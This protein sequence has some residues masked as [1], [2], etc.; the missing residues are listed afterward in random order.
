MPRIFILLCLLLAL[1]PAALARSG[2]VQTIDGR[3]LKG[4][5]QFTNGVFVV[6]GTNNIPLPELLSLSFRA[7][8]P[9]ATAARG[10]GN[11]LLGYYF[12]NTALSGDVFVRL[13]ESIDFDWETAEPG[14]EI[15]T[16]HFSVHWSGDLEVPATGDYQ[17]FLKADDG[18][19]FSLGDRMV[20]DGWQT[21]GG[22]E[23]D[24]AAIGL[25][26]GVRYP[27]QFQYFNSAGKAAVRLM[28]SGPNMP[29]S[30]IPRDRLFAKSNLPGHTATLADE[31]TG[32]LGTYYTKTDFTGGTWS[33]IDPTVD[34]EWSSL[35][36]VPGVSR[37]N[38]SVRWSGQILA[39]YTELYSFYLLADEPFRLWLD[40][41]IL[42]ATGGDTFF[43]E[44]R[45]SIALT[46]GERH[47]IRLETQSTGGN[48]IAKVA[49]SSASTPKAPVP[50]TH[51]F[52]SKPNTLHH[53]VVD[54]ADKSP[55]GI[56]MRN[57][58]FLAGSI[59]RATESSLRMTGRSTP[60]STVN[61]AR[62]LLQP[63]PRKLED[64]IPPGRSG[65]L[66]AKGDFV[67][68]EF[69][70]IENG[71]VRTSSI[72]FGLRTYDAT[73]DVIAIALRSPSASAFT[74]EVQ[75]ADGTRVFATSLNV[76]GDSLVI[77]DAMTGP[78]NI[79][80]ADVIEI[81]RAR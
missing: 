59:E 15:P 64:R 61:I 9:V 42:I 47:D 58:S 30:L 65:L 62:I 53:V 32:L 70:G 33:R 69:N 68:A 41:R 24:S 10:K 39:D 40:G 74:F 27:I 43:F 2:R 78:L 56:L 8:V 71:Q 25:Q 4:D 14:P 57:G 36:P 28:W 13:D 81:R 19:R 49:W 22:S 23:L 1:V 48:A 29:R 45:E 72:L 50:A 6:D 35:D 67:E 34:F 7:D 79:A 44:R 18:G 60:F 17:F 20:I 75:L 38:F 55:P 16:N 37:T 52:P 46:A 3:S 54:L 80:L 31:G 51:L 77:R 5:V 63:L 11:G 12:T 73:R 21:R 66:L 76:A 26:T